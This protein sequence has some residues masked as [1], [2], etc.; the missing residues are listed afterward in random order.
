MLQA[1]SCLTHGGAGSAAGTAGS[2]RGAEVAAA[3]PRE[4]PPVRENRRR[5][6]LWRGQPHAVFAGAS[7]ARV[8]QHVLLQR[9]WWQNRCCDVWKAQ[10]ASTCGVPVYRAVHPLCAAKSDCG[11]CRGLGTPRSCARAQEPSLETA[12]KRPAEGHVTLALHMDA[13]NNTLVMHRASAPAR[14][15]RSRAGVRAVVQCWNSCCL[16]CDVACQSVNLRVPGTCRLYTLTGRKDSRPRLRDPCIANCSL[17]RPRPRA[18]TPSALRMLQRCVRGVVCGVDGRWHARCSR[19]CAELGVP[20][21][22]VPNEI[23]V[24]ATHGGY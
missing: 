12:S 6:R 20:V 21:P 23:D 7:G 15:S 2:A 17:N 13:A 22:P 8:L 16:T 5:P 9:A 19:R 1:E 24:I 18:K 14:D 4:G 3:K 10:S 11:R